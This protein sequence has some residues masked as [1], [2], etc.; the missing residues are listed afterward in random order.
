[1][2]YK[3]PPIAGTAIFSH[4]MLDLWPI[5]GIINTTLK[6]G[7]PRNLPDS[8]RRHP[9]A[10]N[11]FGRCKVRCFEWEITEV[12]SLAY[13]IREEEVDAQRFRSHFQI[14]A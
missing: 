10:R 12:R 1:M 5:T 13:A 11:T 9:T 6:K 8:T 14:W 4:E 2:M 7:S 3:S